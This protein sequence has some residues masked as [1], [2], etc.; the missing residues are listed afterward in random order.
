MSAPRPRFSPEVARIAAEEIVA[1]LIK[2][3]HLEENQRADSIADIVKHGRL[4]SDGYELAKALDDYAH[5]DCN[6]PM[7]E[8]LDGFSW[9]C[10]GAMADAQKK[11]EAETSPQPP[12]P[13]GARVSFGRNETGEITG[14]YGHGAAQ[15]LIKVDGDKEADGPS[16]ARRIVNFEDTKLIEPAAA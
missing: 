11:W 1:E 6:F 4:H 10:S 5:W 13:I 8:I 15:Y 14:I 12:H 16:E 9:A 2:D 7:A 3:G